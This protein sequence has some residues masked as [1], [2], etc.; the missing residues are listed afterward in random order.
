MEGSLVYFPD[1]GADAWVRHVVEDIVWNVTRNEFAVNCLTHPVWRERYDKHCRGFL[2]MRK[3]YLKRR[4]P[5]K[6]VLLSKAGLIMENVQH[7]DSGLYRPAFIRVSSQLCMKKAVLEPAGGKHGCTVGEGKNSMML[8]ANKI[9][10][11]TL[12]QRQNDC[13]LS[14]LPLCKFLFS[15]FT[16]D[17]RK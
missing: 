6:A 9:E 2:P 16:A 8:L 10:T 14:F 15:N 11:R 1:E 5:R 17:S 12:I 13:N 3:P 7:E 4:K